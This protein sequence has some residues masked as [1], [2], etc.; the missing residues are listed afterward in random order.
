M[1]Q[2]HTPRLADYLYAMSKGKA[3]FKLACAHIPAAGATDATIAYPVFVAP[4][5]VEVQNINVVPQAAVSGQDTN[6]RTLAIVNVG[7]DG[8]GTSAVGSAYALSSGHDLSALV[9]QSLAAA[10]TLELD[11]GAV[12]VL[13]NAKTGTGIATPALLVVVEYIDLLDAM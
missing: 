2:I 4:G 3:Q 5:H 9:K 12:L 10:L 11:A 13:S 1:S 7:G 6:Y 8:Q